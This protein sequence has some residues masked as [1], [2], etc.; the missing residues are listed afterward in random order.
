MRGI[1]IILVTALVALTGL[2]LSL[3]AGA[4]AVSLIQQASALF[5]VTTLLGHLNFD[6]YGF[7]VILVVAA[8]A[9]FMIMVKD[10]EAERLQNEARHIAR[11]HADKVTELGISR[12]A[13]AKKAEQLA[14]EVQSLTG[15]LAKAKADL[16]AEQDKNATKPAPKLTD[17]E[18]SLKYLETNAASLEVALSTLEDLGDDYTDWRIQLERIKT[19]TANLRATIQ[20]LVSRKATSE[21]MTEIEQFMAHVEH[22]AG[23]VEADAL[24]GRMAQVTS[25]IETLG[26]NLD[27]AKPK[28]VAS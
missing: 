4:W 6:A 11:E 9:L 27:H 26:K 24:R 5:G 8:A 28:L 3:P 16:K 25:R 17:I 7:Y 20:T 23:S 19:K 15:Q 1:T 13:S 12:N 22:E 14:G 21:A 2:Y 18:S 10:G